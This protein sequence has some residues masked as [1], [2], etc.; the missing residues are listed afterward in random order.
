MISFQMAEWADCHLNLKYKH[1][2]NL[3]KPMN[4]C[5]HIMGIVKLTHNI[6]LYLCNPQHLQKLINIVHD[7][8]QNERLSKF[9]NL[10]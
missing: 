6:I 7:K 1:I 8:I 5:T 9:F 2:S 4:C 3:C 10:W